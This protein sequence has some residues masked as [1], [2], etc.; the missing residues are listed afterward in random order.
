MSHLLIMS[1]LHSP[2]SELLELE[3]FSIEPKLCCDVCQSSNSALFIS[4]NCLGVR[5]QWLKHQIALILFKLSARSLPFVLKNQQTFGGGGTWVISS[6]KELTELKASLS[7]R[8][9][10]KL[11]SQVN[12]S[13]AH[14]KPATL[15]VSE[16]IT[17]PIG[18]WGLTFFVTRAG[19][20]V[21][22]AVTQQVVDST[23]AWIGSK[24]SYNDQESLEKKFTP[25][26]REIGIWLCRYGYYG[27]CGA[28]I[29]EFC[30]KNDNDS[31]TETLN[32][33]DLNVRTSGSL[34]LGLMKGHFSKQRRLHEAS[35]FSIT[36][37]MSRE[38]FIKGFEREFQEGKMVIVS[39]YGD[40]D[41]GVSYGNVVIGAE[42]KERLER[43]VTRVKELASEIHF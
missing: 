35:S 22:L 32:I 12:A 42:D 8:I 17:D 27:P 39:W 7:T 1:C 14:L 2:R 26:M 5:G 40:V 6:P 36:V 29:L 19:E 31:E 21:F 15:I 34:V 33:V 28:D 18:D 20:C 9:L 23:K 13:N 41:S 38:S 43:D 11:L 4:S 10:P 3:D 25:I 16:M 24:I 37:N 30:P